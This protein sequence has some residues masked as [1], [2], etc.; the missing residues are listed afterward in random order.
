MERNKHKCLELANDR[1]EDFTF[2]MAFVLLAKDEV[3]EVEDYYATHLA[4]YSEPHSM[5][6]LPIDHKEP[7]QTIKDKAKMYGREERYFGVELSTFKEGDDLRVSSFRPRMTLSYHKITVL[8]DLYPKANLRICFANTS[9]QKVKVIFMNSVIH[10][11]FFQDQEKDSVITKDHLEPL[12]FVLKQV[13]NKA[14]VIEQDIAGSIYFSKKIMVKA[15]QVHTRVKRFSN[16][17]IVMLVGTAVGQIYFL[18][19]YFQKKKLIKMY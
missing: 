19:Y 13:Q 12:Q 10:P 9:S 7:P 6:R 2:D 14:N 15:R 11:E 1:H 8:K 17:S 4:Q 18:K 3:D 5:S 16:M